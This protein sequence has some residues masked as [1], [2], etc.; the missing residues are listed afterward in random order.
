MAEYVRVPAEIVSAD[1]LKLPDDMSYEVGALVEPI[2]CCVRALD[3]SNIHEGDTVVILGAGFNGVVMGI[4]AS[5]W[6]ADRVA[7]LDRLPVRL[8]RVRSLGLQTFNVDDT[9]LRDQ[10]VKWTGGKGP[11]TVIVTASNQTALNLGFD[12]A[13]PGA[14][15]MLYAPTK[16]TDLWPL[17][18]NRVLFQEITVT[19]TYSSGPSETRR[20]LSILKNGLIDPSALITHYFPI[21][22]ADKAWHMTKQ[23]GD[24]LKVMVQL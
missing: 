5:H 23:A 2:A 12:L 4:L 20:T 1:I 6:G 8:E 11:H 16:P 19:G 10:V 21:E 13:G 18:T 14:T 24:S 7:I 17:N 22:Q 15:I 9:D 3:R